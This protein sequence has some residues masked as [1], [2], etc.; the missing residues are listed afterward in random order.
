MD[1]GHTELFFWRYVDIDVKEN[2]S[3]VWY[4]LKNIIISNFG[5]MATTLIRLL[6]YKFI[7][8]DSCL[9]MVYLEPRYQ[10]PQVFSHMLTKTPA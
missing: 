4:T 8:Q 3:N 9:I 5:L 10:P 7:I 6:S 2:P 1:Y